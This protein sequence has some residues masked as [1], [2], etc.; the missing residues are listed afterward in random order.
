M[1]TCVCT[2]MFIGALNDVSMACMTTT[3]E[4]S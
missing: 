2:Q 1:I 3:F 4:L